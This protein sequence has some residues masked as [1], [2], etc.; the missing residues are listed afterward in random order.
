MRPHYIRIANVIH[1]HTNIK[2]KR[3]THST[4]IC[5]LIFKG[6]NVC[7]QS[8]QDMNKGAKNGTKCSQ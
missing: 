2:I 1:I 4:D 5:T 6:T 8:I 7:V 3:Q